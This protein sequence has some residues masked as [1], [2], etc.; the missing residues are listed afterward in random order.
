LIISLLGIAALPLWLDMNA[1]EN[2]PAKPYRPRIVR[3][4]DQ[5]L[6]AMRLIRVSEGTR[7]D[8][9]AAEPLLANPVAFCFDEQNRVYVA[10]SFRGMHGVSDIR[11]H[12]DWLDEDLAR[13]TVADR[14]AMIRKHLGKG[15]DY[16]AVDHERIRLLEDTEGTDKAD[17]ATVFA[18]GFNR[19]E[20]GIGAG[21]LA[22]RGI[23]WYT[24]IPSLWQLRD[25]KGT[26]EAD[27]LK[28]LH[29]GYGVRIGHFGHDLHGQVPSEIQLYLLQAAIRR[30]LASTREK[31]ARFEAARPA[32][33]HLAAFR[34]ALA[35]G[36][37]QPGQR[38]FLYKTEVDRD[39][40][41]GGRQ[42]VNPDERRGQ[43]FQGR[44]ERNR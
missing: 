33:D 9:F 31:L 17:K 19:L 26:G 27:V 36:D 7:I 38:I 41:G 32:S 43:R 16:S 29:T 2:R 5:P 3:A 10:E 25:T 22:R 12:D 1:Q 44:Q 14:I 39:R 20:E 23:V 15:A 37:A 30:T 6:R 8:L 28:P 18:E 4:T 42:R 40:Q 11:K 35:G 21:L 13:K 34:E 24:C